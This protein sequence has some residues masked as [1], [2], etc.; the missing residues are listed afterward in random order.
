MVIASTSIFLWNLISARQFKHSFV[1]VD[2]RLV[3]RSL[4]LSLF[5]RPLTLGS[6]DGK[7][8]EQSKYGMEVREEVSVAVQKGGSNC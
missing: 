7:R 2:L 1:M 4:S 5:D 8:C 6:G 3:F